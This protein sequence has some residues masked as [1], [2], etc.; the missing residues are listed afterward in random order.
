MGAKLRAVGGVLSVVKQQFSRSN[1]F[2]KNGTMESSLSL[3]FDRGL[4]S[5]TT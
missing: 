5:A 2:P 1:N 4:P 3:L